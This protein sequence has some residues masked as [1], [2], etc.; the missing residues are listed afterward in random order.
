MSKI[1]SY[2]DLIVWKK[3]M[4]LV[5]ALYKETESFPKHEL[6]GLTSQMRRCSVSVS[7]N[8]AEGS[9]RGSRKDF[10]RFI[11]IAYGSAA[12]LQTQIKIASM[13]EYGNLDNNKILLEKT[14]EVLKMLNTLSRSLSLK[15]IDKN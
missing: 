6:F 2:E 12:E 13:L 7:S 14:T 3:S 15:S 5:K 11:R 4:V 9:L 8:I 10:A 1:Q